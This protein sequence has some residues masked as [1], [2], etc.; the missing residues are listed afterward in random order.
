MMSPVRQILR[1]SVLLSMLYMPAAVANTIAGISGIEAMADD[2]TALNGNFYNWQSTGPS[3]MKSLNQIEA[4]L[5][6]GSETTYIFTTTT[7]GYLD[8]SFSSNDIFNGEGADLVLFFYGENTFTFGLDVDAAGPG[9]VQTYQAELT[10]WGHTD[11]LNR[12]YDI[13]AAQI[14][15][16]DFDFGPDQQLLTDIRIFIGDEHKD[17]I[18]LKRPL[19]SHVGAFHTS[20]SENVA[21]VPLPLPVMLFAAGLGVLG[22]TARRRKH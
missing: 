8:L 2:L 11:H 5:A 12:T 4:D 16:D 20:A 7:G 6:D 22:F 14:D 1:C 10:G 15:L 19:L 3:D 9:G 18:D 17:P 13:S 21:P